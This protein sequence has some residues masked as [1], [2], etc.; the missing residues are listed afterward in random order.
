MRFSGLMICT[1]IAAQGCS[2]S[3]A[4][5]TSGSPPIATVTGRVTLLQTGDSLGGVVV[6]ATLPGEQRSAKTDNAGRYTL[7]LP[8]NPGVWGLSFTNSGDLPRGV[9]RQVTAPEDVS[10]DMISTDPPFSLDF[11]RQFV[12]G[13]LD[14]NGSL[15]ALARWTTA[16]SFFFV[17]RTVDAGDPIP[18]AVFDVMQ[19]MAT[20]ETPLLTVGRFAPAGF[21]RRH[22]AGRYEGLDCRAGVLRIHPRPARSRRQQPRRDQPGP[23][24]PQARSHAVIVM[25]LS[26]RGRVLSRDRPRAGILAHERG[27]LGRQSLRH[28]AAG[29][30][31]PRANR[32]FAPGRQRRSRY[33]PRLHAHIDNGVDPL[34]RS[35]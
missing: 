14:N 11:Y 10:V 32:L 3:P 17:T 9:Y 4:T 30:R 1:A 26:G 21:A 5:P 2:G 24:Q 27:L 19:N 15:R 22:A 25:R 28:A 7:P 13:A 18:G 8:I 12:R 23:Y 34:D 31:L 33:G 16:P 35:A 29:R 6:V 20:R